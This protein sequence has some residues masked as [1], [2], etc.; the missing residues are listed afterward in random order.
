MLLDGIIYK[1]DVSFNKTYENIINK[2]KNDSPIYYDIAK[3]DGFILLHL[4][5]DFPKNM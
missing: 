1:I 3:I 4:F 2:K 5:R